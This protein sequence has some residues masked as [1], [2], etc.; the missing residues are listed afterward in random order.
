MNGPAGTDACLPL[1]VKV[2]GKVGE[3]YASVVADLAGLVRAGRPAV[4]VHGG[5]AT[6]D[7]VSL[8]LGIVPRRVVSASGIE[9]RFTADTDIDTL[10]M[11]SAGLINKSLV[12]QLHRD[13]VVAVGL[14]GVDGGMLRGPRKDILRVMDNGKPRLLRGNH[15]GHVDQVDDG[16][17][18]VL[19]ARGVVPV[20]APSR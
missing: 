16:L 11:A 3:R 18:R 17:L 7:E 20:I 5:S 1:V 19:L 2:S 14:S 8:R 6:I 4:L 13:G 12:V 10:L 15:S 9:G